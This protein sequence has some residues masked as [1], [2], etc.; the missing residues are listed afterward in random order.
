MA[1][2]VDYYEILG[3]PRDA[4][5]EDIRKAYRKLARKHHPDVNPG[6]KQAEERFKQISQAYHVL[7][8]AERRRKYDQFGHAWQQAQQGGQ[9]AD[10]DFAT[11]VYEHF[12][13]GSF[14]DMFGDLFGDLGYG[15]GGFGAR[16]EPGGRPTRRVPRRGQDVRQELP[17][18][19]EEAM[20]GGERTF[21]VETADACP[22]CDGLGGTVETCPQCG[23]SGRSRGEGF[24]G[25][26]VS[27]PRCEGTGE[28]VMARCPGCRGT[29]E[30]L[31][32]SRVK[33]RIPPGV[34][35]G[36][37][38]RLA[39][40]GGRG[41]FGGPKGDLI[42][43]VRVKPHP[44]FERRGDD[45]HVKLPISVTEAALGAEV[46]VPTVRGRAKLNV[47]AGSRSGQV[48][49][50]RGQGAPKV[51]QGDQRGDMY[52]ELTVVPPRHLSRK[53]RELF[54]ELREELTEDP[55]A[56]LPEGL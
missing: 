23:G 32:R 44:F 45:I 14:A 31:R 2:T 35:D 7:G 6:D 4:S 15:P 22:Q 46:W 26:P 11:F 10:Q 20:N 53:A 48:L 18:S 54:E 36:T 8:D 9:A 30:K 3:V 24:L 28:V 56:D 33:V 16:P 43:I 25:M 51:G 27:C 1:Q 21:T 19:F 42:F 40:Q 39:G 55:R 41:L 50:L 47:P 17:I 38:L 49:R 52:V 5:Q 29:G 37:P 34:R 12:G 13:A